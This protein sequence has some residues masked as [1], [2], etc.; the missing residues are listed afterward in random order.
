MRARVM[1]GIEV[2]RAPTVAPL[3]MVCCVKPQCI[4]ELLYDPIE[5]GDVKVKSFD[6]SIVN[7]VAPVLMT[8]ENLRTTISLDSGNRSGIQTSKGMHVT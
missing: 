3:C 5:T 2:I 7:V 6:S 8:P 4:D 1:R